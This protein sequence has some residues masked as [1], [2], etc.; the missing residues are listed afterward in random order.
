MSNTIQSLRA[1]S[2]KNN[3]TSIWTIKFTTLFVVSNYKYVHQS[4][5]NYTLAKRG[6]SIILVSFLKTSF[7]QNFPIIAHNFCNK[8]KISCMASIVSRPRYRWVCMYVRMLA[9][10]YTYESMYVYMYESMYVCIYVCIYLGTFKHTFIYIYISL[11][12]IYKSSPEC[13]VEWDGMCASKPVHS[14]FS[15]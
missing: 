11:I 1:K 10:M 15:G 7:C 12:L 13:R 8:T 14:L 6:I 4:Q 3:N 5:L 9:H 2:I